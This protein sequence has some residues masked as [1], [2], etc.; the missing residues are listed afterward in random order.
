MTT[1]RRSRVRRKLTALA[2]AAGTFATMGGCPDV[3]NALL[4]AAQNATVFALEDQ[5]EQDAVTIFQN[6][7]MRS[8][9][10]VF[11]DQLRIERVQ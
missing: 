3:R 10:S 5:S 7:F 9:V 6:D 8:L 2:L 11:Y 1:H 4:D